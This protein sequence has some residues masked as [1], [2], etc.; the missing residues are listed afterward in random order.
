M[1]RENVVFVSGLILVAAGLFWA[2]APCGFVFL[3][4]GLIFLAME[5]SLKP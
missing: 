2:W 3:G 5:A 4:A 1:S